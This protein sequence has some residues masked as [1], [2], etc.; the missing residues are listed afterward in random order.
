[1]PLAPRTILRAELT[2][3]CQKN[4]RYSLRAF[5]RALGMSH[6]VLSLILSGK[7][8]VPRR[9]GARMAESLGLDPAQRR[10]FL[11]L[12]DPEPGAAEDAAYERMELDRFELISDWHHFAILSLL[13]I[14]RSA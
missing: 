14:P 5:A 7:R 2:R 8:P 11:S 9:T 3:R 1:A 12:G 10:A 13:E 4:P 6:T